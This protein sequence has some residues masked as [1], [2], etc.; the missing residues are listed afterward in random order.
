[1]PTKPSIPSPQPTDP[2][3]YAMQKAIIDNI[4][5]ITGVIGGTITA[6]PATATLADVVAK[7][8]ELITRLNYK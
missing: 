5:Q 3:G 4:Q 6:L 2:Y 1:M 7:I 8:N